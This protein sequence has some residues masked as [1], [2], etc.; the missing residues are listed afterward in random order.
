MSR[1]AAVFFQVWLGLC[2]G[3]CFGEVDEGG[4]VF[5]LTVEGPVEATASVVRDRLTAMGSE[6]GQVVPEGSDG[7]AVYIPKRLLLGEGTG[8]LFDSVLLSVW[9]EGE[10][11]QI[12]PTWPAALI[13]ADAVVGKTTVQKMAAALVDVEPPLGQFRLAWQVPERQGETLRLV[14]LKGVPVFT[15]LHV[16]EA[17]SSVDEFGIPVVHVTLNEEGAQRF[18]EASTRLVGHKMPF[19][20]NGKQVMAP[21]I[22]EPITGGQLQITMGSTAPNALHQ[23]QTLAAALNTP[24]LPG[25]LTLN[26]LESVPPGTTISP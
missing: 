25:L 7:L 12:P 4:V 9:A 13:A 10:G 24:P 19:V 8:L 18:S 14:A 23:A 11:V 3:G 15:Q 21:M 22:R 1:F 5:H 16:K 20:I 6:L 26:R 2:L 17:R